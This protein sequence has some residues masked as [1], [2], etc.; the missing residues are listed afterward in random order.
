MKAS[1]IIAKYR[2]EIAE[3]MTDAYHSVI[4]HAG[5][6]QYKIYIW[7]DGEIERL[8]GVQGN[9][10]YLIPKSTES[11]SLYY[12]TTVS[13]PYIN[14]WDLA[15]ESVPDDK[16]EKEAKEKEIIDCLV[17]DYRN[18]SVD[19]IIDN[20]IDYAKADEEYNDMYNATFGTTPLVKTR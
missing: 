7:S 3:S 9:Y 19:D 1:E 14:I 16:S 6:F 2:K 5:R 18:N 15:G 8:A 4:S 20:A 17:N 11:R 12:I 13:E 10:I